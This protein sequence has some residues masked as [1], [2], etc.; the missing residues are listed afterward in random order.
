MIVLLIT[1]PWLFNS[2]IFEMKLFKLSYNT[3]PNCRHYFRRVLAGYFRFAN[4]MLTVASVY[5]ECSYTRLTKFL[6]NV[7]ALARE[8]R[9][10]RKRVWQQ[11]A[12]G[13]HHL[14]SQ[15]DL[16]CTQKKLF[17]QKCCSSFFSFVQ[18]SCLKSKKI[19]GWRHTYFTS[20][21]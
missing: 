18:V 21:E 2:L 15:H 1:F 9:L 10:W 3:Y 20:V 5:K 14:S 8:C 17:Q 19:L 4:K 13:F 7:H 12:N 11:L 6:L 16:M